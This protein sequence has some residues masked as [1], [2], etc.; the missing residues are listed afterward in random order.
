MIQGLITSK[1]VLWNAVSI[2]RS[3]GLRPWLRCLGALLSG[4][5]TTFLEQIWAR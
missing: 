5:P 1:H 2:V 4:R 3:F